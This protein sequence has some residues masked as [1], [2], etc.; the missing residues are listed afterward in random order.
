MLNVKISIDDGKGKKAEI[1]ISEADNLSKLVIIDKVFR[2]F[3]IDSDVFEMV[4]TYSKIGDAYSSFFN[5]VQ[6]IEHEVIHKTD[7]DKN[8]IREQLIQGLTEDKIELENTY[9]TV[10]DQPD[11]VRTG[12]KIRDDGTKLYR[13]HYKCHACWNKGNHWVYEGSIRTWCHRCQHELPVSPANPIGHLTQDTFGNF[14][15]A[16]DF[17]DRN[18]WNNSR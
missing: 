17:K 7:I 16:G 5:D 10:D 12:I 11:F 2:L 4:D 3:G 8:E 6:P 13:L 18:V 9:K 15:V 14:Y 1:E